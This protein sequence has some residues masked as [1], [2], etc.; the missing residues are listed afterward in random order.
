MPA[1]SAGFF[2]GVL[3]EENMAVCNPGPYAAK[4]FNHPRVRLIF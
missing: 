3:L 4:C 1:A 2:L